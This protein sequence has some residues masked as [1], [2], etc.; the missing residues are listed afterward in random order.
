MRQ[1]QAGTRSATAGGG[2]APWGPGRAARGL[3]VGLGLAVRALALGPGQPA[4]D[5][6]DQRFGDRRHDL[7][8][9][10]AVR[11]GLMENQ[12]EVALDAD[13]AGV[14]ETPGGRRAVP[15]KTRLTVRRVGGSPAVIRYHVCLKTFPA[16]ALAESDAAVAALEAQGTDA[17]SVP[18]G[19]RLFG[20]GGRPIHDHRRTFLTVGTAGTLAAAEALAQG[21]IEKGER[22]FLHEEPQVAPSVEVEVRQGAAVVYQ[23]LGPVS[24]VSSDGLVRVYDVE[25]GVGQPWHGR[26]TRIYRGLV[27]VTAD[28]NGTLAAVDSLDLEGYLKGVVPA[29]IEPSSAPETLKAQAIAARGETLA[30]YRLRHLPDPYD[31]CSE[32]HCQAFAGKSRETPQ[33]NAAVVATEGRVMQHGEHLVDAVYS[34]V[35]GGHSESNDK[36]W[37]SPPDP[38]LRGVRDGKPGVPSPVT[39][40]NLEQ[41]LAET[42]A[43]WCKG[44][45]NKFRWTRSFTAAELKTTLA[46]GGIDVGRVRDLWAGARG[47]SG[48]LT[49]LRI[50]GETGDFTIAKELPIRKAFGGLRSALVAIDTVRGADGFLSKVTFRGA[51]WG[52]GVGLCQVG[53]QAQGAAG[54]PCEGILKSYFHGVEIVR[55]DR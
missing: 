46:A 6:F 23:G 37:S 2:R 18:H 28:R 53:A 32:V 35:C 36:V 30:K 38:A 51:G 49:A 40:A 44:G 11:I 8:F 54:I 25:F 20:A 41:F 50:E 29:E 12:T 7:E 17:D 48:R 55:V 4:A 10:L 27:G 5:A 42:A 14:L 52:H 43:A 15:A 1:Q 9:P 34:A 33:T 39:D 45:G 3:C 24:F 22:A 16:A 21:W 26:E 47:V 31:Y 13:A 19:A